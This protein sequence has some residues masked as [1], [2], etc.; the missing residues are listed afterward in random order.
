MIRGCVQGLFHA[1]RWVPRRRWRYGGGA[2]RPAS[3]R[4]R[5]RTATGVAYDA[6]GVGGEAGPPNRMPSWPGELALAR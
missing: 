6:V 1:A 5:L 4:S 3:L 2:G